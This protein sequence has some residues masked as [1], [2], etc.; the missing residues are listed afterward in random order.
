MADTTAVPPPAYQ[1]IA[2]PPPSYRGVS[3]NG[4]ADI[5]STGIKRS[6]PDDFSIQ[7]SATIA[8]SSTS[9][10]PF[11]KLSY[12]AESHIPEA[13]WK[14]FFNDLR[15]AVAPTGGQKALAIMAGTGV[16][17]GTHWAPLGVMVGGLVWKKCVQKNVS[18]DLGLALPLAGSSS[19]SK[20]RNT[21]GQVVEHYNTLWQ[22]LGVR[23]R[24]EGIDQTVP[25]PLTT[26][27]CQCPKQI[28]YRQNCCGTMVPYVN[29]RRA[30]RCGARRCRGCGMRQG[31]KG[32]KLRQEVRRHIVDVIVERLDRE[33]QPDDAYETW[34]LQVDDEKKE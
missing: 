33:G 28:E 29:G 27:D 34:N 11:S 1:K 7:S 16:A 21:I 5:T 10:Q 26:T 14:S 6:L 19:G 8:S 20:R 9:L 32:G 23:V 2:A 25:L 12:P 30:D 4:S 3:Y 15:N 31:R 13:S 18:A 17:I 22:P 24:I